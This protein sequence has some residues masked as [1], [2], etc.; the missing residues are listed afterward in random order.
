MKLVKTILAMV[1]LVSF[2]VIANAQTTYWLGTRDGD[3]IRFET[4]IPADAVAIIKH[5]SPAPGRGADTKPRFRSFTHNIDG[6][7][8]KFYANELSWETPKLSEGGLTWMVD[9]GMGADW[10]YCNTKDPLWQD[11]SDA[12]KSISTSSGGWSVAK[13]VMAEGN[14]DDHPT[15]SLN[16]DGSYGKMSPEKEAEFRLADM[17]SKASLSEDELGEV[18]DYLLAIANAGRAN[19]NYRKS[20][21]AKKHLDLQSGLQPLVFNDFYNKAA[22]IQA[23]YCARVKQA[24]HD[25]ADAGMETVASRLKSVGF[26]KGAYEAA[27][28]GGLLNECPTCWMKSETHH[29]PWWNLEG[30]IVTEVGFGVAKADNGTWYFVAVIG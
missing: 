28:Q 12:L 4:R 9:A 10:K 13:V 27:G 25:N 22:Q 29:K 18:R 19:P 15:V 5:N 24:T 20:A 6:K 3:H 21:G 26:P 16:Q 23:E 17:S 2:A 14:G 1:F 30:E 7:T 8:M 11:F